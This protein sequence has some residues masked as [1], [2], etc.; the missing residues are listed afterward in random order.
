MRRAFVCLAVSLLTAPLIAVQ[1]IDELHP[2]HPSPSSRYRIGT[3][4]EDE[5]DAAHWHNQAQATL[6]DTLRQ[7]RLTGH[8]KNVIMFLGDGMSIPTMTA[9][10]ILLGQ[11]SNT[12]G[13]QAQLSFEKF[14]Y[15]GLSKTYCVDAQTAD[16][17]CTA[18]AYLGGVKTNMGAIGVSAA[19]PVGDC[20]AQNN[21]EYHTTSIARWAQD[22]GKATGVVTTARITH[23]SPAG[24]YAHIADRDWECDADILDS[25]ATDDTEVCPDIALQLV[26]WETGRNFKVLL[27][28]GRSKFIG[29]ETSD[30]AGTKG[31]RQDGRDLISEWLD[32]H[33]QW[34]NASYVSNLEQLSRV[35]IEQ[36]DYLLGLFADSHMEYNLE[37]PDTQPRLVDMTRAAIEILQKD[38]NGYF[39]FVEGARIDMGHHNNWVHKAL[40]ET[41]EMSEAVQLAVDMTN[42]ADTLIVVTADH[43]HTMSVSGYPARGNDIL[44]IVDLDNNKI[45]RMTVNYA[46]GPSYEEGRNITEKDNTSAPD[47]QHPSAQPVF[48]E[49]HGGDDVAVLARG[50]WGHLFVGVYE[51][52]YIPH[53]MAFALCVGD[54]PKACDSSDSAV[55]RATVFSVVVSAVVAYLIGRR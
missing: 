48:S 34:G 19:V 6:L 9:A 55:H 12:T 36:T 24:A 10:R 16:S 3:V 41:I 4:D 17:A 40:D 32:D 5:K 26:T 49:T 42:E 20:L 23:A 38:P 29:N 21:T 7:Q 50:P 47:F 52:N 45:T 28:G 14:P 54:G 25:G 2:R 11:R 39:L 1:A 8:A 15:T 13:E 30:V 33:Q 22:T 37:A 27:G 46:N 43:A 44:G 18:T 53:A 31:S 35:D 51:Q